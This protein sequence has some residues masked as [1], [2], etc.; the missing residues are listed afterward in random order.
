MKDLVNLAYVILCAIIAGNALFYAVN[1][2]LI[3]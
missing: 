2:M 3:S 1:H